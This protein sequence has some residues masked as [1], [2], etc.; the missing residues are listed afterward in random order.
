MSVTPP[1]T[2]T[3][4]TSRQLN[5]GIARAKRAAKSG[6][7]FITHRGEPAYVLLSIEDYQRLAG[8]RRSL[9]EALSMA[10]LA[11]I[12]FQPPRIRIGAIPPDLC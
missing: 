3:T 11:D 1:A 5:Q 8:Q 2:T 4:V 9:A 12:D 7:V 10:G 6:S